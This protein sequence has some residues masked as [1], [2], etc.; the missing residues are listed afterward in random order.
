MK[1]RLKLKKSV[2]IVIIVLFLLIAFILGKSYLNKESKKTKITLIDSLEIEVYTEITNLD[3]IKKINNGEI[4]S[5]K[6]QID[7]SIL[8]Y[9]EIIITYLDEKGEEKEYKFNINIIDT[10]KPTITY[11]KSLT[12]TVGTKIDLLNGVN[13]KDNYTKDLEVK[14][15]GDYD[16]QKVGEY[17]IYY[18]VTDSSNNETK[19]EAKLVV[20]EKNG[21]TQINPHETSN[22][23]NKEFTTPKGFNGYTKNGLTYIDGILIANKTYGLPQNYS[24]GLT[25]ETKAAINSMTAAA[26]IDGINVYCQ[27]GFRSYKTQQNLYNNYSNRNGSTAADIYSARPGHSEHQTGLACDLCGNNSNACI[28][29]NFNNSKEAIWLANNAYKFGLILRYPEGKSNETGYKYESWHYR[30]VGVD[31]ANELYNNGDW[32]T[33][34]NYFGITSEYK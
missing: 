6:E 10:E 25:T 22:T 11:S 34:E 14:I 3:L 7:T 16:F 24:P 23:T 31:L 2:V 9:K 30:Y 32:I 18:T 20:K 5:E 4:K 29:S 19:E 27:S 26:A 12:T 13:A 28:N 15:S 17:T 1:K 33:L 21:D 8:G